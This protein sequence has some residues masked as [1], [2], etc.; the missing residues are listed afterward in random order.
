MNI[1]WLS[2]LVP[3][4]PKG[5]VNQRSYN[6]MK[7]LSKYHNVFIICFSQRS[8]QPTQEK[9]V[10]AVKGLSSVGEVIDVF[11]FESDQS[12]WKKLLLVLKSLFRQDPYTINWIKKPG[13]DKA[14]TQVIADK[15]I[16]LVHFD[17]I[18]WA[19]YL[20]HTGDCKSVLNHHNVESHMML[21]RANKESNLLKKFYFYQEGIKLRAYEKKICRKFDLNITCSS[22]DTDRLLQTLPGLKVATIPNG[23]DLDYFKPIGLDQYKNSIVFAGG[24]SWYPNIAAIEFFVKHV[25]PIL[26]KEIPSVSMK[27]IGRNPPKWLLDFSKKTDN[28]DV[29]GFVDDVRPY[30]DQAS[31][32]VC[33]INDGGGTKLKILDAL[34]MGK[35]I[36][37]NE[38]ACEGI[39]VVEGESVIFAEE[40]Q[41]FVNKIKMLFGDDELR[42]TIG[43][44]GRALIEK[45]YDYI[46]IGKKLDKL[47]SVL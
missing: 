39:N 21:R 27:V 31:I 22:T 36:V 9:R 19:A 3:Y 35:A 44:K 37:A 29:T 42:A 30:I 25:W 34:A 12:K 32:Y 38:I 17:T 46:N 15:N 47:Y 5:G 20:H 10:E 45:D 14:I 26:I 24:L 11:T 2:H 43:V 41:E 1:L 6:L 16:E 18:S 28:F 7:E 23:V 33:P 4:P 13:V 40:P 8:Q